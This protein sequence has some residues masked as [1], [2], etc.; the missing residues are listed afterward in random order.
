MV[1]T[2]WDWPDKLPFALWGYQTSIGTFTGATLY[3]LVYEMEVVL[4]IKVEV[5]SLRV[6]AECQI[7]EADW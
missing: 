1:E 2:Y 5:P 4:S 3:S 6:L 7:A